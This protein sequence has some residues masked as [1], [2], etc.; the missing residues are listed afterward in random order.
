MRVRLKGLRLPSSSVDKHSLC[1]KFNGSHTTTHADK[2][3]VKFEDTNDKSELSTN[4]CPPEDKTSGHRETQ[5]QDDGAKKRGMPLEQ[6]DTEKQ[7]VTGTRDE[8]CIVSMGE[9]CKVPVWTKTETAQ[10]S[11]SSIAYLRCRPGWWAGRRRTPCSAGPQATATG[12]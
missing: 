1:N 8:V 11:G 9:A 6:V 4:L 5:P 2:P 3:S 7:L 10:S 12:Q